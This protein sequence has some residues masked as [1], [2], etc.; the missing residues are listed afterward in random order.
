VQ[1]INGSYQF[2]EETR[3]ADYPDMG[4]LEPVP[5]P[6]PELRV[7]AQRDEL[8][9]IASNVTAVQIATHATAKNP[10]VKKPDA[11]RPRSATIAGDIEPVNAK[12]PRKKKNKENEV[13][14]DDDDEILAK[15]RI[16]SHDD[17]TIFF[18]WLLGADSTAFDIHKT[19]P[20]RVFRKVCFKFS[21]NL[22]SR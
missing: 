21:N 15:G 11:K 5:E 14:V 9:S 13:E 4:F 22:I 17:K 1:C 10:A 6:V 7:T 3:G 19:N 8:K 20:D 12:K 18:E 2:V 16:W